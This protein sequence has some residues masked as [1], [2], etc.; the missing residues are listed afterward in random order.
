MDSIIVALVNTEMMY[1]KQTEAL[2]D[3]LSRF[4]TVSVPVSVR[5]DEDSRYASLIKEIINSSTGKS[6]SASVVMPQ[7]N[8]LALLR[9]YLF[10]STKRV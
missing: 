7:V 6:R 10:S 8:E 1:C 9:K 2:F 3:K 4:E 5:P